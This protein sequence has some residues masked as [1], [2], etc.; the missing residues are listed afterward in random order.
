MTKYCKMYSIKL[1]QVGNFL[2]I[3]GVSISFLSLFCGGI[4]SLANQSS[5]TLLYFF[6]LIGVLYSLFNIQNM[7]R[8]TSSKIGQLRLIAFIEGLSYLILL[9][10]AMPLKKIWGIGIVSKI[11]GYS[12]GFLF[13]FFIISTFMVASAY[14]W[15]FSK[16]T[17]KVLLSS[18]IP[19]GTF[20]VDHSIFKELHENNPK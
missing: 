5:N 15:K 2:V 4:V 10:V 11:V 3:L 9:F 17:W 12:H 7:K 1:F 18:L 14:Q 8:Y 16:T 6:Y 19:F 13:I 20:Y